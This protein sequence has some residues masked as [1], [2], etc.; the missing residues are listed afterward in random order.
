MAS[1]TWSKNKTKTKKL[2]SKISKNYL[3]SSNGK[4]K[5]QEIPHCPDCAC[6]CG[7]KVDIIRGNRWNKFKRGH[8]QN[9][10][11][12]EWIDA[13]LKAR[14]N[15]TFEQVVGKKRAKEWK[16]KIKESREGY[17]PTD[18]TRRKM[19]IAA[20]KR[21]SNG[22]RLKFKAGWYKIRNKKCYFRSSWE[23]NYAA[24]LQY[25]KESKEIKKWEY[26]PKTFWFDKIKRGVTN[27]TPDFRIT[28]TDDSIEYHEVKG[29]MDSWSK[30]KL[31]RMSIYHPK[32]KMVLIDKD[33]YN[34]I[35]Q[36]SRMFKDWI[37]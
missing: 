17:E 2:H 3:R 30:T 32:I 14:K 18:V 4:F 19:S 21:K 15:K 16:N 35:K 12:K 7:E 36:Y 6:G 23:N 22:H 25:L 27:Y 13:G 31:K 11:P 28:N 29:W 5:A 24:Y 9:R 10:Y 26:E 1:K 8:V 33:V 37:D 34:D 20:I